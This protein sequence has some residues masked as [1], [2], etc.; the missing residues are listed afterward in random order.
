MGG[1]SNQYYGG[2]QNGYGMNR[3]SSYGGGGHGGYGSRQS[4]HS[5][6]QD[7]SGGDYY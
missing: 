5:G 6:Y 2:G 1:M 4:Y 3:Y 7:M